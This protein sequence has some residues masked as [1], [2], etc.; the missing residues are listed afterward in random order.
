MEDSAA[1]VLG[2]LVLVAPAVL[3]EATL[4]V[5]ATRWLLHSPK[6]HRSSKTR[7]AQCF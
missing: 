4:S 7:Q 3:A 5:V 2:D 6:A 1:A